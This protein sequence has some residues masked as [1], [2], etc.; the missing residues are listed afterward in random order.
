MYPSSEVWEPITAQT[1]RPAT[2][3]PSR[4]VGRHQRRGASRGAR[5]PV[6]MS[7]RCSAHTAPRK[8]STASTPAPVLSRVAVVWKRV[9]GTTW[10]LVP[11]V[12]SLRGVEVG[13]DADHLR[14]EVP[15]EHHVGARAEVDH[16]LRVVGG[17]RDV[18][19]PARHRLLGGLL[20]AVGEGELAV[21]DV[22]LQ[23]DLR[24]GRRERRG[25]RQ[26]RRA[27]GG[28]AVEAP[29]GRARDRG[30]HR[31][32]AELDQRGVDR[33]RPRRRA[34]P[35]DRRGVLHDRQEREDQR[36]DGAQP[37]EQDREPARAPQRPVVADGRV[38][39]ARPGPTGPRRRAGPPCRGR[40]WPCSSRSCLTSARGAS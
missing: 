17:D 12:G 14:A 21:V 29:D 8:H 33:A 6:R 38:G 1:A 40:P 39:P 4:A 23:P 13:V 19:G 37:A 11:D 36:E 28:A 27:L 7:S 32:R 31:L 9:S 25:R 22:E 2:T 30:R 35:L 15:A 16:R 24:A 3:T 20:A 34:R 10:T 26:H 18:A 5:R